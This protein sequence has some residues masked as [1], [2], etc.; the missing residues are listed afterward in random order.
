[1]G[2]DSTEYDVSVSGNNATATMSVGGLEVLY[3]NGNEIC[4]A[5][6]EENLGVSI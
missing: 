6:P 1:M 2:Y 5:D 3:A 4:E